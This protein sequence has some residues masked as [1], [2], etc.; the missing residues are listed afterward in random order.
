V[1]Q[2]TCNAFGATCARGTS[3]KIEYIKASTEKKKSL[4]YRRIIPLTIW[5]MPIYGVHGRGCTLLVKCFYRSSP[6]GT[7]CYF[8]PDWAAGGS[9]AA[10]LYIVGSVGFLYVDVLEFITFT[11]DPWLRFNISIS[12][13]GWVDSPLLLGPREKTQT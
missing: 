10:W 11:E 1:S 9:A 4:A 12:A 6:T 13:T 5:K 8:F 7:G 2:R 3:G